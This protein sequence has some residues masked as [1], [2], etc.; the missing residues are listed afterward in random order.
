[1]KVTRH[2]ATRFSFS[3]DIAVTDVRSE[4]QIIARTTDL[5]LFGCFAHTT[6]P[7]PQGTAV[8]L[9]MNRGDAQVAALGTIAYSLANEGMG[10]EFDK[11]ES[12]DLAILENWL[13]Q[14]RKK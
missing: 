12:S 1:M 2:R 6:T 14:L 13:A 5:S 10:I 4:K 8:R 9:K 7:F 3:A 11:V